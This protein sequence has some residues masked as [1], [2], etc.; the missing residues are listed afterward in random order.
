MRATRLHWNQESSSFLI[1]GWSPGNL[2][3]CSSPEFLRL[4]APGF[5]SPLH[6]YPKVSLA[7]NRWQ[8][9]VELKPTLGSIR[10]SLSLFFWFLLAREQRFKFARPLRSRKGNVILI[11]FLTWFPGY[12]WLLQSKMPPNGPPFHLILVQKSARPIVLAK[13]RQT[14][15]D[16]RHRNRNRR[17][18]CH[19]L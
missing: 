18:S 10:A 9:A 12:P 11:N 5:Q 19:L 15:D 4:F 17:T 3:A 13:N 7:N 6:M 16:H 14:L 1:S 8:R 2:I